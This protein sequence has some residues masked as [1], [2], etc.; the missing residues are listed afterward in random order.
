MKIYVTSHIH[1]LVKT[2][3]DTTRHNTTQNRVHS[4]THHHITV[5]IDQAPINPQILKT[6]RNYDLTTN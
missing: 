6:S 5:T 4:H 2:E 1:K 3:E